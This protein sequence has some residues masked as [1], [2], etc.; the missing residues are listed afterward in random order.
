M[1]DIFQIWLYSFPTEA[2]IIPLQGKRM[3]YMLEIIALIK[4]VPA[5]GSVAVDPETGVL[6]RDGAGAKLNP[7]DLFAIETAV[8]LK[9]S[10]GGRVTALSMGPAQAE[11][12]LWE[13]I[14]MG[15]DRGVL[16]SDRAFAGSDVLATAYAL[17]NAI[18]ALGTADII[19]CGRQTTDGDTAQVGAETAEL[20]GIPHM[21]NIT[22]VG[23]CEGGGLLCTAV[24]DGAVLSLDM[25]MPCLISVDK[26]IYTPR[27]PSYRRKIAASKG[28]IEVWDKSHLGSADQS[29]FGLSGSPTQ[30]EKI[31][32]PPA[33]QASELYTGPQ[34][35]RR[36]YELLLAQKLIGGARHG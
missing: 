24:I 30:V 15:A 14:Y 11:A 20:L 6:L 21:N 1:K 22:Q 35:G 36:L 32:P 8:R 28:C 27:L 12:A 10:H 26:D 34:P 23:G 9:E 3:N 31:F 4:Q 13:A 18:T 7:Y 33:G 19:I 29:R 25:P 16:L 17:S 2:A 5:S